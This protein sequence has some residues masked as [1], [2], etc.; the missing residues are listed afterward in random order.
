MSE[1]DKEDFEKE[2][3]KF[4]RQSSQNIDFMKSELEKNKPNTFMYCTSG[5]E[6]THKKKVIENLFY[7]LSI[8]SKQ[9]KQ[10]KQHRIRK[11]EQ[12]LM[13]TK[14]KVK[15]Y[16][17]KKQQIE[18]RR[19]QKK[20]YIIY[21]DEVDTR[22]SILSDQ[23]KKKLLLENQKLL[24]TFQ[25][26]TQTIMENQQKLLEI[27]ELINTMGQKLT[28]Q[29][30]TIDQILDDSKS[31]LKNVQKSNENLIDS[32]KYSEKIGG[33]WSVFFLILSVILLILDYLKS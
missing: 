5:M 32:K 24:Y 3:L 8:V 22:E 27:S 17:D 33:R 25:D 28:D 15:N 13:L 26:E 12:I 11:Q 6:M 4:I 23:E 29:D 30:L 20:S 31:S 7:K 21:N 14:N 1:Q 10:F 16:E 2:I 18:Q 19:S 9:L